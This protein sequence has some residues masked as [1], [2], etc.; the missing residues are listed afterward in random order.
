M[1]ELTSRIHRVIEDLHAVQGIMNAAARPE[2]PAPE[3]DAVMEELI[4]MRVLDEFKAAV[5]NMRHLLWS[6]IEASNTKSAHG[7][8]QTLQH[9][10]MQRVTEMLRILQPNVEESKI[11]ASPA[12]KSFF[13]VIQKIANSAERNSSA[14]TG[15]S[16]VKI[17]APSKKKTAR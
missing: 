15:Q 12:S 3:R 13:E 6:Y 14:P 11:S 4:N 8:S 17:K 10:R 2:A 16:K 9:V 7:V 1:S 5:D